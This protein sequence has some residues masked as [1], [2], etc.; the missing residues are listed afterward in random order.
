MLR[1]YK[2][3]NL[4]SKS[5]LL[6]GETQVDFF[7]EAVFGKSKCDCRCLHF[8]HD[9]CFLECSVSLILI[10]MSSPEEWPSFKELL[11]PIER[12][13]SGLAALFVTPSQ[14]KQWRW[15][16]IW[17]WW[18]FHQQEEA[19]KPDGFKRIFE[20]LWAYAYSSNGEDDSFCRLGMR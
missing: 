5:F 11:S 7:F 9:C 19:I 18:T 6:N 2:K 13:Q 10:T 12:M 1:F 14:K 15:R 3:H 16:P 17:R 8:W 20:Q 4:A